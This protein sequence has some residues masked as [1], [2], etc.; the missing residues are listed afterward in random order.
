M[1]EGNLFLGAGEVNMLKTFSVYDARLSGSAAGGLE[2]LAMPAA[3][4]PEE[5]VNEALR[6]VEDFVPPLT[7]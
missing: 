3:P 7:V 2:G 5:E 1:K 6:K 4:R